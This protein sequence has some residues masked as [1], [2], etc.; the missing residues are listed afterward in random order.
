MLISAGGNPECGGGQAVE[1]WAGRHPVI[2]CYIELT[3][4]GRDD[5][6]KEG[7]HMLGP[8]GLRVQLVGFIV[9][10]LLLS[11]VPHMKFL[12]I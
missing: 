11:F 9:G 12:D 2:W 1:V 7:Y 8:F 4:I 10:V 3:P 6:G 5:C